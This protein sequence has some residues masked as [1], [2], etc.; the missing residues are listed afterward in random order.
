MLSSNVKHPF[1]I[2]GGQDDVLYYKV[3]ARNKPS[4]MLLRI[5]AIDTPKDL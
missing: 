1:E 4:P 2:K 5:Y 3:F